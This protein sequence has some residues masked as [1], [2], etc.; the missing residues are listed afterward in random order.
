MNI[1]TGAHTIP[2]TDILR[3]HL[4]P[5]FVIFVSPYNNNHKDGSGKPMTWNFSLVIKKWPLLKPLLWSGG[6][7]M[8]PSEYK[9]GR[10]GD[11]FDY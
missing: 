3:H 2:H 8:V 9:A 7:K 1:V 10:D 11:E 4:I 5:N 6:T